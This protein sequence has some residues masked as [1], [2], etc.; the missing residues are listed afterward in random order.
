VATIEQQP[1]PTDGQDAAAAALP[2]RPCWHIALGAVVLALFCFWLGARLGPSTVFG[3][4]DGL[5]A[6][7]WLPTPVPAEAYIGGAVAHP[8][9]YPLTPNVRLATLLQRAGGP[10][11]DA[12]LSRVH[13]AAHVH[14]GET[15]TIPRRQ[16]KACA[17]V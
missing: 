8:G 1:P 14:D 10:T 12:D 17:G 7:T 3:S 2:R 15:I 4:G 16:K 6:G 9:L 11:R 13:L 5:S